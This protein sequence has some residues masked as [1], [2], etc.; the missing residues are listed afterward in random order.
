MN[1]VGDYVKV[2]GYSK[3]PL[4]YLRENNNFVTEADSKE[5]NCFLARIRSVSFLMPALV[6]SVTK[7][8][9]PREEVEKTNNRI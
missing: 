3:S 9:W 7:E 6:S 2:I 8:L 1:L 4:E 5:D